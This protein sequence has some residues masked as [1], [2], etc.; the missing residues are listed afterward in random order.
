MRS[1]I[2]FS[3]TLA[4]LASA[5]PSEYTDVCPSFDNTEAAVTNGQ[6][7]VQCESFPEQFSDQ[8][9]PGI[10]NT[11]ECAEACV[12]DND[13]EGSVWS[14]DFKKCWTTDNSA[15]NILPWAGYVYMKK[16]HLPPTT[17][18]IP[19]PGKGSI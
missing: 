4:A 16:A 3:A 12:Q 13:C 5:L 2:L 7:E 14:D 19:Q 1:T 8:P 18:P 10:Q 17:A 9:L 15:V 6:V 11:R